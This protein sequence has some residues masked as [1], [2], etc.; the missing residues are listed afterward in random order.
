MAQTLSHSAID[1]ITTYGIHEGPSVR[2][3]QKAYFIGAYP[4]VIGETHLKDKPKGRE[5]I[6]P[7]RYRGFESL[8]ALEVGMAE[9]EGYCGNDG[10]LVVDS[11]T[12]ENCTFFEFER[13]QDPF[14]DGSGVHGWTVMTVLT[15]RQ[16]EPNAAP[17]P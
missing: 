3:L 15:F 16:R 6:V 10:S 14:L 9:L 1:L 8:G 12:Y 5:I 11:A 4:G 17:E 2:P 7:V 13:T